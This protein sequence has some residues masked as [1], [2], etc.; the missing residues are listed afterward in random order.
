[1][2]TLSPPGMRGIEPGGRSPQ[3]HLKGP[4]LSR[5][6]GN[7]PK[8]NE[9]AGDQCPPPNL[10]FLMLLLTSMWLLEMAAGAVIS[11]AVIVRM[12][13]SDCQDK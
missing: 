12:G 10:P 8:G 9:G 5:V 4:H 6:K 3:G 7:T 13:I 1:M 11:V 2:P